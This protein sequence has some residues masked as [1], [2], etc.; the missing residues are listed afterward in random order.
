MKNRII[1]IIIFTIGA[2]LLFIASWLVSWWTSPVWSSAPPEEFEGTL[3]AVFGPIFMAMSLTVPVAIVLIV[4]GTLIMSESDKAVQWSFI[5]GTVVIVLS[6]LFPATLQFYPVLYGISGGLILIFFFTTF[7]YWSKNQKILKGKEKIAAIYQ[8]ISYIFFL[9]IAINM[10]A[11]LGNPISGLYFPE[12][13]IEL[14]SLPYY[15]AMGLKAAI[16]FVLGWFFTFLAQYKR[17]QL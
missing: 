14:E 15:Y 6:F 7:W 9:L 10:C 2:I 3:W 12:K 8:L 17:S 11:L 16:Y 5:I 1:G 13:V 4:I